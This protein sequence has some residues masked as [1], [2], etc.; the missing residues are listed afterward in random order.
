[1]G[2]S[3]FKSTRVYATYKALSFEIDA[4][5]LLDITAASN[6]KFVLSREVGT[7]TKEYV[8]ILTLFPEEFESKHYST[9][10]V[11]SQ[12]CNLRVKQ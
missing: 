2:K 4:K 1:V 3:F 9:I 12:K 11:F 6:L 8:D 10:D 7:S 5:L